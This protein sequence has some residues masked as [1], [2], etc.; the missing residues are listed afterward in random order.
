[1]K[2]KTKM[3]TCGLA[4]LAA[5]LQLGVPGGTRPNA[6]ASDMFDIV[7]YGGTSAA[8]VAAVQARK[9]GKTV[10]IVSPDR[11]L[12]GMTS[13]GL[14]FTDSGNTAA[15]GGLA[16]GFYR[17]VWRYYQ[18]DAAWRWQKRADYGN[19]G[20]GTAAMDDAARTMW[21]FEPHAAEQ[22][23]DA[24]LAE[25]GVEVVRGA[26]LDRERGVAKEG[27]RI[28]SITSLDGRTWRGRMFIDATFE[29]DLMAAAGV[30]YH[31]GR[32]ANSVY[33]ETWNGNQVGV[34]HHAHFFRR[35]VD[36][37]VVPGNPGSGLLPRKL[38]YFLETELPLHFRDGFS[39]DVRFNSL[40]RFPSPQ[41]SSPP[42][43]DPFRPEDKKAPSCSPASCDR[44]A[45]PSE[46]R[47]GFHYTSKA[48]LCQAPSPA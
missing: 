29:G 28:V 8:V 34:L 11:H 21:T 38:D 13:G 41:I 33:G 23:F 26:W 44:R 16:R 37:Y 10:V 15:I 17:R 22:V 19:R 20:Q 9:M 31:V 6:Q 39:G 36:P 30:R 48:A 32:E 42:G 43:P 1:M 4:V 35:P 3:R 24:W 7:I 2:I 12:G 25:N 46:K 47:G 18:D 27:A 5:S 40:E 45:G 14:G